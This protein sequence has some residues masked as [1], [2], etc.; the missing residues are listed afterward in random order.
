MSSIIFMISLLGFISLLIRFK[1]SQSNKQ[2]EENTKSFWAKEREANSIRKKD[3]S[4]LPYIVVPLDSLPFHDTDDISISR[5]QDTIRKLAE[6]ELLN[7]STQ[8]NTDLKLNYGAANLPFLTNCDTGYTELIK[9]L[10]QW[11]KAL[12]DSNNIT[13]AKTVLEFAIACKTDIAAS[14]ILLGNI[15]LSANNTEQISL[16]LESAKE[17]NSPNKKTAITHLQ[18]ILQQ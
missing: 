6:R 11:G 3:I 7:L 5:Y 15:Y 14:Y 4:N 10:Q 16:L 2:S 12:Y 18:N 17:M 1:S 8:T 13:D 9:T